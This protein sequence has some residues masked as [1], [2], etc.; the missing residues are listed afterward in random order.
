VK[1]FNKFSIEGFT[2]AKPSPLKL[3]SKNVSAA[4]SSGYGGQLSAAINVNNSATTTFAASS[5]SLKSRASLDYMH[6]ILSF[7][8]LYPLTEGLDPNGATVSRSVFRRACIPVLT[9]HCLPAKSS[10]LSTAPGGC[11]SKTDSVNP[12]ASTSTIRVVKSSS[13]TDVTM[14]TSTRTAI[15]MRKE[16]QSM[17]EQHL[18]RFINVGRSSTALAFTAPPPRGMIHRE[19]RDK[20]SSRD[21]LGTTGMI[22]KSRSQVLTSAIMCLNASYQGGKRSCSD[23]SSSAVLTQ[24]TSSS[25]ANQPSALLDTSLDSLPP[26]KRKVTPGNEGLIDGK[27]TCY[28]CCKRVVQ[29]ELSFCLGGCPCCGSCL[30]V[31]VKTLLAR[32]TSVE[33]LTM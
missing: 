27:Q 19:V 14:N 2:V 7:D 17:K 33:F 29:S 25:T 31:Q 22:I 20:T 5:R 4:S 30:Q 23:A 9:N 11:S 1:L 10:S 26:K 24:S 15:N 6:E 8:S 12:T 13:K 28:K 16:Y 21:K 32:Q 18:G 3:T